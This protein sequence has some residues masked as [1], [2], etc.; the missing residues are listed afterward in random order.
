MKKLSSD[1]DVAWGRDE[2]VSSLKLAI[3]IAKLLGDTTVPRFYPTVFVI[4]IEALEK[5]GRMVFKRLSLRAEECLNE[6]NGET[7]ITNVKL[8]E[9]FTSSE[10]PIGA[11]ET[12]RNWFYK[13]ACIRELLP[14]L[15]IEVTLLK[16]YRFISDDDIPLILNRLAS[17]TR[18]LGDPL[19]SLYARTA[20]SVFSADICVNQHHV[21]SMVYDQISSFH[22]LFSDHHKESLKNLW[23]LSHSEYV[24]LMPP[25]FFWLMKCV[26]RSANKEI[27]Q[28]IL[29]GYRDY[30]NDGMVLNVILESF[31]ASYYSH[32]S[33]GMITLIRNAHSSSS[34]TMDLYTTLGKQFLK[35]PPPEDHKIQVLN[36]VWKSVSK[37]E[38]I[39][40]YIVCCS[41][42]I[43]LTSTHYS[44]REVKVLLSDLNRRFQS[45]IPELSVK[46]LEQLE[47][48]VL[49]LLSGKNESLKDVFLQSDNFLK[50]IDAFRLGRK[51]E[52][53][54]EVLLQCRK[55]FGANEATLVNT[56]FEIGR[57]LHDSID[58]LSPKGER[59]TI[60]GLLNGFIERIDFDRNLEQ[61]LNSYVECRAIF[62]NLDEVKDKLV[63]CVCNLVVRAYKLM[64]GKHSKKTSAF[65]KAC[66]AFCQITIPSIS[67]T[68]R[69]LVLL[70][71]CS[72]VSLLNQCLPQTDAFLKTAISIIPEVP[73]FIVQ[74][75]FANQGKMVHSEKRLVIFIKSLLSFL[76][77]VPGHPEHGPFYI[78]QGLL[79]AMKRYPWQASSGILTKVYCDIS[80]LLCSYSQKKFVYDV[81][82]VESNDVLYAGA[83]EYKMDLKKK[84][85][86]SIHEVIYHL[87]SMG[88]SSDSSAKL[89]QARM[90][91]D[92]TN[93]IV[94]RM[95]I[96]SEV[97]VFI[98]KLMELGS[99]S[100]ST[101]TRSDLRYFHNTLEY[102]MQV[103]DRTDVKNTIVGFKDSLIAMR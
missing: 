50:I 87:T 94:S 99:K 54:K 46:V 18:G 95:V 47:S 90:I 36:E 53:C 17:V 69:K 60:A 71:H 82:R 9:N 66:L 96:N 7:S 25:G 51:L 5:F 58:S 26:T 10:V 44:E 70:Y 73:E 35:F 102:V 6:C 68:L 48:S 22:M 14:R 8:P 16:C 52:I 1:L 45:K 79:N 27:F 83:V 101:F 21:R 55:D 2:R 81:F 29:H 40:A 88:E 33:L 97:I 11:K 57:I 62:S 89:M 31:D 61:Q 41:V 103:F 42:W 93:Q 12:C 30:C 92:L 80:A 59:K 49:L 72:Q 64:K 43:E 75:E 37:C 56:V 84:L 32:G 78:V 65:V 85:N 23:F 98:V 15:L 20:I 100:K 19:V 13:I 77:L 3:Q 63:V 74:E 4:V 86:S 34:T 28:S 24:S 67:D 76:L 38:D 91:L 39:G